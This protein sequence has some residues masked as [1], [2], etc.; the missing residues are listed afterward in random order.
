MSQSP[1]S[2]SGFAKALIT[3]GSV[4]AGAVVGGMVNM[5]TI[6]ASAA[7]LPPPV[8]V[9]VNNPESINA[10]IGYYSVAQLLCPF[11][12]HAIGTLVGAYLAARIARNVGR[13]LVAAAI[14]GGL[15]LLGGIMAV[16]MIPNAPLWFDVLDLGFAY[17]P[18][19]I[20]GL[21]FARKNG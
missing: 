8:G 11:F 3:I 20:L 7:I 5:G 19:A 17:M 6:L 2:R 4:L 1:S 21:K 18:M 14:V 9:D 16:S 15:F 13:E 10:H 12:A